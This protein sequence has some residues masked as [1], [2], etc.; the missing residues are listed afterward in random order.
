MKFF[1]KYFP[2]TRRFRI[3]AWVYLTLFLIL[4][5][6]LFFRQ[7]WQRED[8]LEKERIQGQRRILK[9]G[10]RGDVLDRENNLLIGNRGTLFSYPSS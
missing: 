6:C 9:P 8:Y 2:E 7:V 1:E 10:A 3:F 4:F 5:G